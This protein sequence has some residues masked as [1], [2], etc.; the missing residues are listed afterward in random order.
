MFRNLTLKKA[1]ILLAST[2]IVL[3]AILV[4]GN[5]VIHHSAGKVDNL[6]SIFQVERSEKARLKN[7]LR[8]SLGY[9]HMIHNF[10]NL[11]LRKEQ[12]Y[13]E[14]VHHDLGAVRTA[15]D[16][17]NTLGTNDA[18]RIALEDI[19]VTLSRYEAALDTI[20]PL[21]EYGSNARDIDSLATVNDALA[22]RGLDNLDMEILAR[23]D[24]QIARTSKAFLSSQIRAGLGYGGLIHVFKNFVLRQE[25]RYIDQAYERLAFLNKQILA[26]RAQNITRAEEL[27]LLDIEA[28]I[29]AYAHGIEKASALAQE[30]KTPEEIDAAVRIDDTRAL[31]G[32]RIIDRAIALNIDTAAKEVS[33]TLTFITT[34]EKYMTLTMICL[35]VLVV[36]GFVWFMRS[37]VVGP[38]AH[39]S[40][41][42]TSLAKGDMST[43]ITN[44]D[45]SNEIGEMSRSVLVFRSFAESQK[46]A[47][48]KLEDANVELQAQLL[49]FEDMRERA[50][51]EAS[52][53]IGLAED[54]SIAREEAELATRQ[55]KSDRN[56]ISSILNT[57][58]DGILTIT[59]AGVIETFNP[60]AE[61]LFGYTA[62]E[63]IGQNVSMLM[64]EPHRTNHD[65]YLSSFLAGRPARIL[66]MVSEQVAERKDGTQFAIELAVNSVTIGDAQTF[67]GVIRDI[68][69]RKAAEEEI[70][71]M[72]MTD[73]LTGL[74]NRNQFQTRLEDSLKLAERQDTIMGLMM[75]DLDK[76][77]PVNDTYGHPAGDKLLQHVS[78]VLLDICRD[79]DVVARLGGDEFAIILVDME[80]HDSAKLPSTRIIE[81]LTKPIDIDGNEISIGTSIG[82]SFYPENGADA[83]AL[84]KAADDALY[85]AKDGGRNTYRI[86]EVMHKLDDAV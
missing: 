10:K 51:E 25:D 56:R 3:G 85:A 50:E 7:L 40:G 70:L 73:A 67:T 79:T 37:Q 1:S 16:Q 14:A 68:T 41:I 83:E 58:A 69:A 6:W 48:E 66:G 9:G 42:M 84:I 18:E 72:A 24:N 26:Y 71:R 38:I 60:A 55:A 59:S 17:Y 76:F 35:I 28:T 77:K 46:H 33:A 64:P 5:Q 36:G 82:I 65:K 30:N 78:E 81:A 86:S 11:V 4:T 52:K 31:R 2:L 57:V 12:K 22:F 43:Q 29:E 44:T 63:A 34:M 74:A 19:R 23:N 32:L 13:A 27:A 75:L 21:I 62:N 45:K 53:A 61:R 49:T 15:I 54:L 47:E 20:S 39:L 8:S 80:D